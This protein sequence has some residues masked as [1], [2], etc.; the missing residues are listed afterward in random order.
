MII[1]AHAGGNT[2]TVPV[3]HD[4][5]RSGTYEML[6]APARAAGFAVASIEF[7][8][9]VSNDE[10]VPPPQRDILTAIQFMRLSAS[11]LG[12]DADNIF[13]MGLRINP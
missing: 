12:I 7:R 11:E 9:P 13:L 4:P 6:I 2:K 1:F 3:E 10:I 8:H 5:N